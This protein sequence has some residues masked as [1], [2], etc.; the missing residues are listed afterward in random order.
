MINDKLHTATIDPLHLYIHTR[1]LAYFKL[2]LFSG[3]RPSDLAQIKAAESLRF[4]N[5]KGILFDHVLGK[6][7]AL[8]IPG[9]LPWR[10]IQILLFA[11]FRRWTIIFLYVPRWRSPSTVA[12]YSVPLM[13][14]LF[15]PMF[16]PQM[17]PKLGPRA[18][19]KLPDS[20]TISFTV[21]AAVEPFPW[22]LLEAL[23][24]TLWNIWAG[25]LITWL[26]ITCSSTNRSYLKALRHEWP[27]LHQTHPPATSQS[28]S[29]EVF[30]L[31]SPWIYPVWLPHRYASHPEK[32]SI[33]NVI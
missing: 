11:L 25:N 15:F 3:D 6:H 33:E 20:P 28:I 5:D 32:C 31:L 4:P 8:G 1:D 27:R 21:F 29:F 9:S 2:H 24:T 13:A 14:T 22:H 19:W 23:W 16:S 7:S 17:L 26:G 18:T 30:N 10:G 12:L